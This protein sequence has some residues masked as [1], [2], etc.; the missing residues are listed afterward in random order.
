LPSTVRRFFPWSWVLDPFT[1]YGD[2]WTCKWFPSEY[3]D[4]GH[5]LF[6]SGFREFEK[7]T[8]PVIAE[9]IRQSRVF[10]DVGANTG[11]YTILACKIDPDVRVV[12]VEP[13][14]QVC[15]ALKRNVATNGLDSRVTILNVALG[16]AEGEAPF[17]VAERSTMGSLAVEGY[18]GQKGEVI[19][20][21][22]RTLDSV[23]DELEVKP[24][25]LK[26]DVEGFEHLVLEGGAKVLGQF[27][28]RIAL[29][30]NPGDPGDAMTRILSNYAYEFRNITDNGLESRSEIVPV[31][32]YHNW[33]CTPSS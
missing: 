23:V 21:K 7:E 28:P 1:V 32:A 5:Q 29:E 18:Q 27:R 4:V 26:I 16:N 3:D 17:H 2:G 12:A 6:W 33:L 25:F 10:I 19:H 15:A 13:V 24:D 22:C 20:V 9:N 11:I 31:E 14:P 8:A 30:A